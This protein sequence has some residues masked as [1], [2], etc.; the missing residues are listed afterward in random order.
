MDKW[1]TLGLLCWERAL[2]CEDEETELE[3]YKNQQY[4]FGSR[5][6]DLFKSNDIIHEWQFRLMKR[7]RGNGHICC[8]IGIIEASDMDSLCQEINS[9]SYDDT[10]SRFI[11]FQCVQVPNEN[12]DRHGATVGHCIDD[13]NLLEQAST[14]ISNIPEYKRCFKRRDIVTFAVNCQKRRLEMNK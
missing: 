11:G 6:F 12:Q 3:H 1:T 13:E 8:G 10:V 2:T 4:A 9:T 7:C 5:T 14:N